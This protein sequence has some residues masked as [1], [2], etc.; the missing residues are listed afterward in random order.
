MAGHSIQRLRKGGGLRPLCYSELHSLGCLKVASDGE[1][2]ISAR[3]DLYIIFFNSLV[4]FIPKCMEEIFLAQVQWMTWGH[5]KL[6]LSS[7][8]TRVAN[9][10]LYGGGGA[11]GC[12]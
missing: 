2:H 11:V 1:R 9:P 10:L 12:G 5:G 8:W 6:L 3:M 7:S 4:A